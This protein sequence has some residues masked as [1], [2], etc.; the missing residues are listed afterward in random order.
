[1]QY[2]CKLTVIDKKVFADLQE[3]Y[4]ED[5]KSGTCPFYEVGA[6]YIFERYGDAPAQIQLAEELYN[7]LAAAGTVTR[8]D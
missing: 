6:E 5:P 4:L 7:E 1:M 8:I 2:K 3:Q